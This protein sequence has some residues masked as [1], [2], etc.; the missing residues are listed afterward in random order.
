MIVIPLKLLVAMMAAAEEAC[1]YDLDLPWPLHKALVSLAASEGALEGPAPWSIPVGLVDD[2]GTGV[3]GLGAV[4]NDLYREGVFVPDVARSRR[5]IA[6]PA[7]RVAARRQYLNLEP[8]AAACVY[9]AA[10]FWATEA[11][12]VSKNLDTALWSSPP[13]YWVKPPKPRHTPAAR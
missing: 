12:T 13:T 3:E 7:A 9:R 6:T 10:R 5:L 8:E 11:L 4:M 2:A 1:T